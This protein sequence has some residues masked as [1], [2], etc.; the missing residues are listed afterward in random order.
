MPKIEIDKLSPEI[1]DK[2]RIVNN[3]FRLDK[4]KNPELDKY[5]GEP[6]DEINVEIGDTKQT[7]FYPQV[8]LM[9][10]SNEVNFSVRLKD[11][12]YE[13]A[14]ISTLQDKIKWSKGN[15]EIEYYEFEKGKG[16]YK[17]V[18][19]LKSKPATNKVEFTIQTKG[20]DFFY[21][22]PLTE[23]LT[24]E[25]KAKGW[26]ADESH[27]YDDKGNIIS[28]RPPEVVGSY[29]VYHQTKG[30]MV[31]VNG[32]DYKVGK[33]FHIYR[34]KIIDANGNWVWGKLNIDVKNGIYSVEIPQDFLDTAV[35]P[36]KS[37]DTFGYTTVGATYVESGDNY[38][39]GH[40]GIPSSNGN[41]DSIS[42]YGARVGGPDYIKGVLVRDS[43]KT[44]VTNG[45]GP[46]VTLTTT[47][48]WWTST[49]ST[50]PSVIGNSVYWAC[51]IVTANP[52]Y[53][54]DTGSG[55]NGMWDA[56]NSYA[57][58]QDPTDGTFTVP[59]HFSV[60]ATYTPA[61]GQTYYQ[62][63]FVTGVSVITLSSVLVLGKLLS[64]VE[65]SIT[66][67]SRIASYYRSLIVTEVSNVV[68]SL[69]KTFYR[70]LSVIEN[71]IVSLVKGL[72]SI[73]SVIESSVVSLITAKFFSKV[74][75]VIE[76]SIVSLLG[77]ATYL[78]SLLVTE[79]SVITMALVK[80]FYRTLSVI[81]SSIANLIKGI[82]KTLS[83]VESS[84]VSLAK[85]LFYTVSM[86]I[87]EVS[88][89]TISKITTWVK[90]LSVVEVSL[91]G[92]SKIASF[93]RNLAVTE[94]SVAGLSKIASFFR[95]LAATEITIPSLE[96]VS[97]FFR[98][99]VTTEISVPSL[100]KIANY[101]RS[102]SV[103][104]S[105]IAGLSKV[106]SFFRSLVVTEISIPVMSL[107]KSFYRTLSSTAVS[108]AELIANKISGVVGIIKHI[109]LSKYIK[110]L[111]LSKYLK[112]D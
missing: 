61:G 87:T 49:Y 4:I 10:W 28:Y 33:A 25:Q 86:V 37:N 93:F 82:S 7:E 40:I 76:S 56:T 51:F 43:D 58:P 73:L 17:M 110:G 23:E 39:Y 21:Q 108:I 72:F 16:G 11:T 74:L 97:S 77:I 5:T 12:E 27:I 54:Y 79:V 106:A 89:A 75:S 8:K 111:G 48:R 6:K 47:A 59:H 13:K 50:K 81:E 105:S 36:I 83:V 55:I 66:S 34:P 57:T 64:V 112:S 96:K 38:M 15:V 90:S 63:L 1:R 92:L 29:A 41:V 70:T 44:I 46:G 98:D 88:A 19:S 78:K 102:L 45:V 94:I 69:A 9:R 30:G 67:L 14:Q 60:Y 35:Y 26:T 20:L 84:V 62:N 95:N 109:R 31:D 107:I 18:W 101:F 91:A 104:E 103:V 2:Y 22:P 71:S 3:A 52:Y 99:L 65:S 85:G 42:M 68:M 100:G 24:E 32:K 80:T 53:Y